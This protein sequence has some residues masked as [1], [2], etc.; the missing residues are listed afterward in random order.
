MDI[1]IYISYRWI[2]HFTWTVRNQKIAHQV[3]TATV[4]AFSEQKTCRFVDILLQLLRPKK[5]ITKSPGLLLEQFS[6]LINKPTGLGGWRTSMNW[7]KTLYSTKGNQHWILNIK[8]Q[9]SHRE[10]HCYELYVHGK[11][12]FP[13]TWLWTGQAPVDL[14][15]AM[16]T[17]NSPASLPKR[18]NDQEM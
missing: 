13:I 4:Q 7:N 17:N 9:R 8:N 14:T 6:T 1:Y 2:E 10:I 18:R 15:F 12:H 5:K 16:D 3:H 11:L